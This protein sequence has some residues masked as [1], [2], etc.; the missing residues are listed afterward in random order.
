MQASP[1]VTRR[2]S[3]GSSSNNNSSPLRIEVDRLRA[4]MESRHRRDQEQLSAMLD[5][6]MDRY[7]ALDDENTRLR[8]ENERLKAHLLTHR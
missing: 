1:E 7:A 5:V 2:G 8:M 4:E 6:L 3:N